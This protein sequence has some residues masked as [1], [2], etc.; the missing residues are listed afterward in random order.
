MSR[1]DVILVTKNSYSPTTFYQKKWDIVKRQI[2]QILPIFFI[3]YIYYDIYAYLSDTQRVRVMAFNVTFKFQ[4]YCGGQ[5]YWWRKPE[6][7]TNLAQVTEKFYHI[8]LYRVHLDISGI[9]THYF[10]VMIGTD[11]IGSCKSNER[12]DS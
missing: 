4:Q 5:F 12:D 2:G 6:K 11:C 10:I 8:M 3:S 7:T 9:Q 1:T